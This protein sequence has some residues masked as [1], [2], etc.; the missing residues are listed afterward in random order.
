MPYVIEKVDAFDGKWVIM[1]R[2]YAPLGYHNSPQ[3]KWER[4]PQEYVRYAKINK[5]VL[6]KFEKAGGVIRR[7]EAGQAIRIVLYNDATVPANRYD[8][9]KLDKARW[10]KYCKLLGILTTITI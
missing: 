5:S 6:D 2:D 4:F 10:D 3:L 1:N 7:D 8:D 9:I